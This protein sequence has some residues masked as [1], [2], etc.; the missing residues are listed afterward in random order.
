MAEPMVAYCGLVCTECPAHK[1]TLTNDR[2]LLEQTAERWSTPEHQVRP[3]DILCD[4]CL[5]GGERMTTFCAMC[6]VRACARDRRVAHCGECVDYACYRL[7]Q[8]WMRIKA[9]DE[10]KPVLDKLRRT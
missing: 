3:E 10:A 8:H 6:P 1:A 4:G 5:G 7:E 9:K 2:A